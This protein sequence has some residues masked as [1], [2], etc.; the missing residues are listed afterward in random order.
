M[1]PGTAGLLDL[2]SVRSRYVVNTVA[3]FALTLEVVRF[4][5]ILV[6]VN[7][8]LLRFPEPSFEV[9]VL[10]LVLFTNE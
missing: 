1:L 5:L 6:A 7:R 9:I 8:N 3:R 10:T 4:I 2:G